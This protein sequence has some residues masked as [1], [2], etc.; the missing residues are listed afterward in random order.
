MSNESAQRREGDQHSLSRPRPWILTSDY[1]N[2]VAQDVVKAS[3]VA[4]TLYLAGSLGGFSSCKRRSTGLRASHS[5]LGFHCAPATGTISL[6]GGNSDK[7]NYSRGHCPVAAPSRSDNCTPSADSSVDSGSPRMGRRRGD[8]RSNLWRGAACRLVHVA[9]T[10]QVGGV[11]ANGIAVAFRPASWLPN[12]AVGH[13]TGPRGPVRLAAANPR[14]PHPA[15]RVLAPARIATRRPAPPLTPG[16]VP[17][18]KLATSRAG[19]TVPSACHIGRTRAVP[20]GQ[21]R[22]VPRRS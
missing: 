16:G 6:G 21:P 22:S 15:S 12:E 14:P 17:G 20:H 1:W 9:E 2:S 8:H 19:R 5:L 10:S 4:F 11:K 13:L 7:P 3:V 18:L